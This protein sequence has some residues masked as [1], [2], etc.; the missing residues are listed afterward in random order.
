MVLGAL[1]LL[2]VSRFYFT[3]D[4]ES[5][6]FNPESKLSFAS[7]NTFDKPFRFYLHDVGREKRSIYTSE[8]FKILETHPWRTSLIDKASIAFVLLSDESN[9]PNYD[10]KGVGDEAVFT[11]HDACTY[12]Q[13]LIDT[14][15]KYR[16]MPHV[17]F[18]NHNRAHCD[19]VLNIPYSLAKPQPSVVAFVEYL[20]GKKETAF[21][22]STEI[23][24]PPPEISPFSPRFDLNRPTFQRGSSRYWLT[25]KGAIER[26]YARQRVLDQIRPDINN[27]DIVFVSNG[28]H[29]FN[30]QNLLRNSTFT[31]LIDGDLPW[32]YRFLEVIK[33]GAIP[34]F[35]DAD[36]DPLPFSQIIDWD[37]AGVRIS[38]ANIKHTVSILANLTDDLIRRKLEYLKYIVDTYLNSRKEQVDTMLILLSQLS[39]PGRYCLTASLFLEPM[40]FLSELD[41]LPRNIFVYIEKIWDPFEDRQYKYS[42]KRLRDLNPNWTL[43]I[44]TKIS[45]KTFLTSVF[46]NADWIESCSFDTLYHVFKF[47]ILYHN[48]GIFH[49]LGTPVNIQLEDRIDMRN[50]KMVLLSDSSTKYSSSIIVSSKYN[51]LLWRVARRIVQTSVVLQS[52]DDLVAQEIGH[53]ICCTESFTC[54]DLFSKS[55]FAAGGLFI[56]KDPEKMEPVNRFLWRG[57]AKNFKKEHFM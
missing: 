7:L 24:M 32:S 45:V 46:E 55:H 14:K 19:N 42:L 44:F 41:L 29:I 2:S 16:S 48:G 6:K 8:I 49:D 54:P 57:D 51:P 34:V 23:V 13:Q 33:S 25:F 27:K 21:D 50:T 52:I 37:K 36:W 28:D 38:L 17:V 30:Y 40:F 10:R 15:E 26:G 4:F 39:L 20:F 18:Y 22:P 31:F 3:I 56:E 9:Y 47:M 1:A 12:I 35:V 11:L 43:Q 53:S 5:S